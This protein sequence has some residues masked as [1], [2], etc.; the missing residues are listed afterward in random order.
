MKTLVWVLVIMN[1]AEIVSDD[2][3]VYGS[4]QKCEMYEHKINR[5]LQNIQRYTYSAYCKPK[6]IDRPDE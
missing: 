2:E 5:P 1:Q 4:L 3:L 6:V